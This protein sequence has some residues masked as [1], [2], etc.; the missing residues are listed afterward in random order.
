[1]PDVERIAEA[2]VLHAIQEWNDP[3]E[4][5]IA[6]VQAVL[7]QAGFLATA[8]S[9]PVFGGIW[10]TTCTGVQGNEATI[11]LQQMTDTMERGHFQDEVAHVVGCIKEAPNAPR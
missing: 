7:D 3:P 4:K 5:R 9:W 10:P 1:M 2:F 6:A 8:T 11:W